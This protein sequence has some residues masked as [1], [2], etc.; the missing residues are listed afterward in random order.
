[1]CVLLVSNGDTET[2]SDRQRD[3]VPVHTPGA[4][5]KVGSL[6]PHLAWTSEVVCTS[7]QCQM[8]TWTTEYHR[9]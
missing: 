2:Y 6:G 7:I 9:P 3:S 5:S 1:M 4:W 8:V